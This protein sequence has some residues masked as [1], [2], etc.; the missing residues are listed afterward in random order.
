AF[1]LAF[2][3]KKVDWGRQALTIGDTQV[4]VLPNPSGLNRATLESLVLSYRAL[5]QALQEG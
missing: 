2:G 1:S 3:I 5:Y 4:W